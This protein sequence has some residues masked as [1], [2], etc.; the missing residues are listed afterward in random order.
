MNILKEFL[1][2]MIPVAKFKVPDRGDKVDSSIGLSSRPVR[3]HRLAARYDNPM[4]E[5]TVSPQSG[6]MKTRIG[7]INQPPLEMTYQSPSSIP[8][9]MR[10]QNWSTLCYRLKQFFRHKILDN[11]KLAQ[12]PPIGVSVPV[13]P[14]WP[15]R[16]V[17]EVPNVCKCR[18]RAHKS[19]R[20]QSNYVCRQKQVAEM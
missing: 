6:T 5:P 4:P 11:K 8:F 9:D 10:L 13:G 1:R 14:A 17:E 15:T 18:S 16:H 2:L 19:S 12:W 7:Y 3:L 20:A